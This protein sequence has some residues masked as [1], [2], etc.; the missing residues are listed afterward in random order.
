MR[1]RLMPPYRYPS[2]EMFSTM[3]KTIA[4]ALFAAL[5]S[6]TT[7]PAWS[8]ETATPDDTAKFLAGLPPSADSPL[9]PLA[10]SSEWE[11]HAHY[12]DAI[13]GQE[14]RNSLSKIR[15]FSQEHLPDKH[16]TMLYMLGGPDFLYAHSFFPTAT[17]YVLAA[18]EPVG[19]VPQLTSLPRPTVDRTLH[20]LE[21][22]LHTLLNLSFFITHNMR[23][24][25]QVGPVYG[26]LPILY[27]FLART[28]QTI[29]SVSYV[30]L[31]ADGNFETPGA[32][33]AQSD[34]S[35][36]K[37]ARKRPAPSSAPGVKIVFSNGNGPEQ[38][39]YYFSTNL[40]DDGLKRSG[41][42]AFCEKLGVADSFVKS[43]SYLLHSGNFGKIRSFL[44]DHSGTILQDDSGIPLAYFDPSKWRLQPVGHYVGPIS[45]FHGYY[46]ARMA[47]LFRKENP[48]PIDFG[49]G[50]RW[51][52][53]ETSMLLAQKIVPS[54]SKAELAPH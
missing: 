39:L 30:S 24:Q 7:A 48:I 53:N 13:F 37:G 22:S 25:L 6:L 54:A 18:L 47:E 12:F 31:G 4:A 42:L 5:L 35:G 26:T 52:R 10:K 49:L 1:H 28:G 16:Q 29:H 38:T 43:D 21:S 15:A 46:Q 9:A 50:Y 45:I 51:R 19:E 44:L 11:Q 40:G 20:N 34:D 17:T 2:K 32:Q 33:T 23:S 27:V 3:F 36:V 8:A 41:F 14:E